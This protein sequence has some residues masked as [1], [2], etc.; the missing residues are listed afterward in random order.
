MHCILLLGD[1]HVPQA[2]HGWLA[3]TSKTTAHVCAKFTFAS[4]K[5]SIC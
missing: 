3:L 1:Q 2:N 5:V 4:S